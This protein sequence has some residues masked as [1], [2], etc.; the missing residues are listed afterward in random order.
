MRPAAARY[1]A[2]ALAV[3]A[4]TSLAACSSGKPAGLVI[5]VTRGA[6][7]SV[8]HAAGGTQTFQVRNND[9][10]T[11]EV[12]LID[13]ATGGVYAQVESLAPNATRTMRVNLGHG[14]YAFACF[15]EDADLV[16]GPTEHVTTGPDHGSRPVL[17]VSGQDL[18]GA[19]DTYRAHVMTGITA[20]VNDSKSLDRTIRD[21][22]RSQAESS[23]LTAHLAYERL[24]AAYG[25]FGDLADAIDGMPDGLPGGV[26]DKDFTGFHRIEYGLWHGE[27]MAAIGR[28]STRLVAG[29]DA[30]A[31]E[32]PAEQTDPND[33]P[34]R[35]HEIM[36]NALQFQL[37]GSADQGSGTSLATAL[38]NLDGTQM[39]LDALAPVMSTR[40]AGWRTVADRMAQ[41][42]IALSAAYQGKSGWTPVSR[43]PAALKQNI[44][45]AVGGLLESLAPIAEI[46]EV[47]RTS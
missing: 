37:T 17:P 36:E 2:A 30:L 41:A 29:T 26:A 14:D 18:K 20:L 39:V 47:R 15:P 23:W 44:D 45:G 9:I 27:S 3:L 22:S 43:L 6:C 8:W 25:T 28:Y 40:Y 12:Y 10:V 31:E 42:R 4:A 5:A 7:G 21:G 34:L 38:A 33:L 32:F 11:T 1:F 35:A 16:T 24:G 46:G 13:P 19:V